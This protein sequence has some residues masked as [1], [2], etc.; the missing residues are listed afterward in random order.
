MGEV[1][2][3][4]SDRGVGISLSAFRGLCLRCIAGIIQV[5][6]LDTD[7]RILGEVQERQITSAI[8][9]IAAIGGRNNDFSNWS[10]IALA[11][12]AVLLCRLLSSVSEG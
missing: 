6:H 1:E 7:R 12:S 11:S 4:T 5:G 3:D 8:Q 9:T 10:L 2:G